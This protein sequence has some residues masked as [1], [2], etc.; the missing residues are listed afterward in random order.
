MAKIGSLMLNDGVWQKRQVVPSQ[1]IRESTNAYLKDYILFGKGYGYQWWQGESYVGNNKIDLF[2]ATGKGGQYIFVCPELDLVTVV[3]SEVRNNPLG[4]YRPQ[5]MMANYIIPAVLPHL[6]SGPA[7]EFMIADKEK[8]VGDYFCPNYSMKI[9][10]IQ[11]SNELF[12]VDPENRKGK[13]H[14]ISDNQCVANSKVLGKTR[15]TFF[16]D[17][18]KKVSHFILQVG[19]GFWHFDK[20]D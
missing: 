19:F 4:E 1:W 3:T 12:Y 14:F 16:E 15:A 18:N 13:L 6:P 17:K 20:V 10:I 7:T 2:Y 11:D 5:M 9:K 8:Y